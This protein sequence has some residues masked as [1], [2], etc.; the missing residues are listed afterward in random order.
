[1]NECPAHRAVHMV[2]GGRVTLHMACIG[3]EKRVGYPFSHR[4]LK[5]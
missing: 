3:A 5:L 1:M 2:E 4:V